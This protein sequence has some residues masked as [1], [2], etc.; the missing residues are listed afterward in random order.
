MGLGLGAG[1]SAVILAFLVIL[2]V[3]WFC[4]PFAVFGTQGKLN[5]L[6]A[7]TKETN[8]HLKAISDEL[9]AGDSARESGPDALDL[10]GNQKADNAR[11]EEAAKP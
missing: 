1:A 3:L 6:I 7:A 10:A 8:R 9:A 4:L 11:W 5:E 2:A